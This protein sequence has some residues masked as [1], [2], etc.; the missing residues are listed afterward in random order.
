[1]LFASVSA[2]GSVMTTCVTVAC[3][4]DCSSSAGGCCSA[5]AGI[6]VLGVGVEVEMAGVGS[7]VTTGVA[8]G[9][10]EGALVETGASVAPCAELAWVES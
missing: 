2:C 5:A 4:P 10:A 9:V 8:G 3:A 1:M 7:A 6:G